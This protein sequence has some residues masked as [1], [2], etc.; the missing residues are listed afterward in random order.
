M[1]PFRQ[2]RG[3]ASTATSTAGKKNHRNS[4]VANDI[5]ARA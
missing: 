3:A 2:P 5:G 1:I 4:G